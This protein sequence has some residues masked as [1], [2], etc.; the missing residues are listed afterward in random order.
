MKFTKLV[1][2]SLVTVCAVPMF[3]PCN[4]G[5]CCKRSCNRQ[6][7]VAKQATRVAVEQ[8]AQSTQAVNSGHCQNGMCSRR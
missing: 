7:K 8:T 6:V 5:R 3:G 1:A 2:L 4:G